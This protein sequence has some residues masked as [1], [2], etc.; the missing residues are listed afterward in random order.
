VFEDKELHQW[1]K[2]NSLFI[3]ANSKDMSKES[4]VSLCRI[5]HTARLLTEPWFSWPQGHLR[6]PMAVC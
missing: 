5:V 1:S 6:D 3:H 2:K 4:I